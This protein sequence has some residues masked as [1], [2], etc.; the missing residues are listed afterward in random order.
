MVKGTGFG[1]HHRQMIA[2][3][4]RHVVSPR[5]GFQHE[6][7]RAAVGEEIPLLAEKDTL[8][9]K[10]GTVGGLPQLEQHPIG[11]IGGNRRHLARIIGIRRRQ[12]NITGGVQRR[13]HPV[14][15]GIVRTLEPDSEV[16]L[17]E[18]FISPHIHR[19]VQNTGI[20]GQVRGVKHPVLIDALVNARRRRKKSIIA[21]R[22]I[23][24]LRLIGDVALVR[25]GSALYRNRLKVRN[26]NSDPTGA[27]L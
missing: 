2:M 15:I 14:S 27:V 1:R 20:A 26:S 13:R 21:G 17:K 16:P 24:K 11:R 25:R 5:G 23:H 12:R 6:V 7:R 9:D 8:G 22:R 19:A 10:R 3:F 4:D 18:E